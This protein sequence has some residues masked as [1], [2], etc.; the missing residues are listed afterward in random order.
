MCGVLVVSLLS[1]WLSAREAGAGWVR[2]TISLLLPLIISGYGYKKRL[3]D[4]S[5]A[6]LAL[7]VGFLLTAASACFS[8]SLIVFFMSSSRLTKWKASE[9]RK[10][11]EDYREGFTC[12]KN[13]RFLIHCSFRWSEE[14]G[15]SGV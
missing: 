5:G 3:L 1:L 6:G 9:K 8:T 14:L 13:G 10:Q 4:S 2:W 15:T 12:S 11:E 7:V